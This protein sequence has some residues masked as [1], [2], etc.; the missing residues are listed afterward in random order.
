MAWILTN[1]LVKR[2]IYDNMRHDGFKRIKVLIC[3]CFGLIVYI[4]CKKEFWKLVLNSRVTIMG[5]INRT[6]RGFGDTVFKCTSML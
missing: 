4:Y 5:P 6:K 1:S 2:K 3:L